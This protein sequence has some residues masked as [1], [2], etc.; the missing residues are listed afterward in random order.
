M[1][2]NCTLHKGDNFD[3]LTQGLSQTTSIE[4]VDFQYCNL[5]DTHANFVKRLIKEQFEIKEGLK[6]SMSL[7]QSKYVNVMSVGI[8]YI[9]LNKNRFGDK[10]AETIGRQL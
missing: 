6:F 3:V 8:K 5:N 10:F 7:R 4:Y 1:V 2:H 9:N